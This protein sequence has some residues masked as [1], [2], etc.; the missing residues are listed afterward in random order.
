[1][2]SG[3]TAVL[4]EASDILALRG[5]VHAAIDLDALGLAFLPSA[6]PSDAVMY[7]NLRSICENYAALDVQRY[8]LARAV[9]N[10]VELTE[11]RGLVAA[12]NTVV[13]RLLASIE[14]MQ[15]R[16]EIR[17]S[18]IL[19]SEYVGR[20]ATLNAILDRDG[21]AGPIGMDLSLTS[22]LS[23]GLRRV[24]NSRIVRIRLVR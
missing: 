19:Q 22:V 15:R 13:C 1:M 10:D 8:L 23:V 3:K 14:T 16:V 6:N 9:E 21:S 17:D 7:D 2:G 5:I 18:G 4:G 20:V 24:W 11:L 12:P